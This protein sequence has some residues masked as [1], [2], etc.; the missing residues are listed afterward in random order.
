MGAVNT[1]Y[2]FTAT[3]TITSAKM[4][5]IIDQTTITTDAIIGTTLDVASGKLKIRS[6]GITSN[7]LGANSVV[8]D[9]IAGSSV[10]TAKLANSSVTAAKIANN[11]ITTTK[12]AD[13]TSTTTGITTGKI[14]NESITAAK[15]NG[16]Q[17][18]SAPIY[19]ARAWVNFNGTGTVDINSSGNVSSITDNG[20]GDYTINFETAMPNANYSVVGTTNNATGNGGRPIVVIAKTLTTNSVRITT[21]GVFDNDTNVDCSRVHVVVFG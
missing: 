12:I 21:T 10:T 8:T 4:N 20:V 19:G 3:D 11:A 16:A 17:S 15:L 9:A 2:T 13:S 18:G 14:A 6:A 5:N 1:T 7:E